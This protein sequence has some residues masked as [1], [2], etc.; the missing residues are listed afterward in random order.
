MTHSPPQDSDHFAHQAMAEMV[1]EPH[2]I[3]ACFLG[4]PL[5]PFVL[6]LVLQEADAKMGLD[7]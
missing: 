3:T 4:P 1:P 5:A 7:I 2:L 6:V